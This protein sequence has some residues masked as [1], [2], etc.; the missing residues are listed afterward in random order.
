MTTSTAFGAQKQ[1]S[2]QQQQQH[3]HSI[4]IWTFSGDKFRIKPSA[5]GRYQKNFQKSSSRRSS[6]NRR[7]TRDH[8][9]HRWIVPAPVAEV[10]KILHT[11]SWDHQRRQAS[12]FLD[13]LDGTAP[14]IFRLN[15]GNQV[16]VALLNVPKTHIVKVVLCVGVGSS[17]IEAIPTQVDVKLLF[18]YR[19]D[20]QE[21]GPPQPLCLPSSIVERKT[22]GVITEAQFTATITAKGAAYTYPLLAKSNVTNTEQTM[23]MAPITPYFVYDGFENDLNAALILERIMSGYSTTSNM[24]THLQLFCALA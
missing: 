24:F 22:V 2:A 8:S 13:F 10:A 20:N 5:G 6:D 12:A 14:E 16:H 21:F 3:G 11:T 23:H 4:R 17:P 15:E 7:G 1:D 9:A 19:D 18:L